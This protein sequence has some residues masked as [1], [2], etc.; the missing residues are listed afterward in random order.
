MG[1][2]V[3]ALFLVLIMAGGSAGEA[4]VEKSLFWATGGIGDGPSS[5]YSQDDLTEW[6]RML[7]N[8]DPTTEGV[9]L[10]YLGGLA[11]T[12]PAVLTLRVASGGGVVY[13]F[14]YRSTGNIDHTLFNPTLGNTG[15]RVVLR[16]DWALRTVRSV[17]LQSTDGVA[18]IPGTTQIP[19][20]IWEIS[21][22]QGTVAIG[23]VVTITQDDRTPLGSGGR[24]IVNPSDIADRTRTLFV[25]VETFDLRE[26]ANGVGSFR[27][28]FFQVPSDYVSGMTIK[29]VVYCTTASGNIYDDQDAW[30]GAVGANWDAFNDGVGPQAEAIVQNNRT[31]VGELALPD[32]AIGQVV[33]MRYTREGND[34]LDTMGATV[35]IE[36]W[37]ITYTADS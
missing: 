8:Q 3:V 12:A 7:N 37:I 10:D 30:Y 23:G 31:A 28:G 20:Y 1:R 19:G 33:Y 17:L 35:V 36:G 4:Q 14:P 27:H 15:W 18:A 34:V 11:V 2:G 16:T 26:M 13:G 21:L 5:G 6:Q 25:P 9:A 22:A 32:A 29:S 24:W